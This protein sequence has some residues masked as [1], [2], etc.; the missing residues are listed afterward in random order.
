MHVVNWSI[1]KDN[2][3]VAR[4]SSDLSW[5]WH[6]RLRHLNFKAIN[7]LARDD[8]VL[9]QPNMVYK[10]DKLCDACQRGKQIKFL[11]NQSLKKLQQD[12]LA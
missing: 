11:S 12:H 4:G 8:L 6:K 9:G 3:L 2:S 10:K 1:A 7:K 5:E